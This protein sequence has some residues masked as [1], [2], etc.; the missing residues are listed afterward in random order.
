MSRSIHVTRRA[1][2]DAQAWR[3]RDPGAH[4]EHLQVLRRARRAKRLIKDAVRE[5]RRRPARP[6]TLPVAAP[7]VPIRT[8]DTGPHVLHAATEADIRAVLAALPPGAIDGLKEIRL[9]LDSRNAEED[10]PDAP[11]DP[12]LG[13]LG[14]EV[15]PGLYM[16][17][18]YGAWYR[19]TCA[20]AIHAHVVD[21]A[22]ALPDALRLVLR[23]LALHTLGHEI[24]HH[25]DHM[26][27]IAAGRW[28]M[29]DTDKNERYADAFA[30]RWTADV[31][32][33][34]LER[35]HPEEVLALHSLLRGHGVADLQLND[36]VAPSGPDRY[37]AWPAVADLVADERQRTDP[38]DTLVH[39]A[40]NLMQCGHHDQALAVAD[41]LD[42]EHGDRFA[43]SY[44]RAHVHRLAHRPDRAAR[45]LR[46]L[47]R[48]ARGRWLWRHRALVEEQRED[49]PALVR[50]AE[51]VLDAGT[52]FGILDS[53]TRAYLEL[54][55]D[56]GFASCLARLREQ[57][58][59]IAV[60]RFLALRDLR[61]G[62][63]GDALRRARRIPPFANSYDRAMLAAIAFEAAARVGRRPEV[64]PP[65]ARDLA[66]LRR[67]AY[68][69]WV[70]AL[71]AE[72]GLKGAR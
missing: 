65:T 21:D 57:N 33:P 56:V 62:R 32:V 28:R 58:E 23:L 53:L 47:S 8:L 10:D 61:S 6:H 72:F 17:E 25:D 12:W 42:A 11:R 51:R 20:I 18:V 1:W 70:D 13:R 37:P 49:W 69:R 45:E 64:R 36:L 26:R 68:G 19:Q 27:R 60:E 2:L 44:V 63:P 38:T 29:D 30:A 9:L 67:F 54:G 7:A 14:S 24:A 55:D 59:P 40:C 41:R 35:H 22:G 52:S 31:V 3:Y 71:V 5:E 50:A 4:Q 15:A 34:Y 46:A 39:L 16:G 66:T 43:A 48:H